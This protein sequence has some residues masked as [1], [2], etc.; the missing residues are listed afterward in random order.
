MKLSLD[1]SRQTIDLPPSESTASPGT[2]RQLRLCGLALT[3]RLG[4][5]GFVWHTPLLVE[6][7]HGGVRVQRLPIYDP[8]RLIVLALAGLHLLLAGVALARRRRHQETAQ[9][10]R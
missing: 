7:Y 8:T 5:G 4:Q 1:M 10:I 6:V 3:C 9:D 2:G